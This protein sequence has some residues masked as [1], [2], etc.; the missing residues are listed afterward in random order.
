MLWKSDVSVADV[1][2]QHPP[3]AVL[4]V[5]ANNI[6]LGPPTA[7]TPSTGTST[8]PS[9][10]PSV[11]PSPSVHPSVPPSVR[12]LSVRTALRLTQPS[13]SAS[14]ARRVPQTSAAQTR[15][16]LKASR[17]LRRA[18]SSVYNIIF[19]LLLHPIYYRIV[20]TCREEIG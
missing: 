20:C 14:A 3:G 2:Y 4:Q 10:R 1:W 9:V 19:I 15:A 12:R 5:T 7:N 16:N 13:R 11:R 17:L 8:H 6:S 18:N